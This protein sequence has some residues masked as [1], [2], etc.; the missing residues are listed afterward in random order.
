MNSELQTDIE[1]QALLYIYWKCVGFAPNL[2][3]WCNLLCLKAKRQ[4]GITQGILKFF[5]EGVDQ[6]DSRGVYL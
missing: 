1:A 3:D 5:T 4:L 6:S 2:L